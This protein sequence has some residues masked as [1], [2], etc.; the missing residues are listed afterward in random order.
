MISNVRYIVI[1]SSLFLLLTIPAYGWSLY[2]PNVPNSGYYIGINGGWG[3]FNPKDINYISEE[4]LRKSIKNGPNLSLD[5]SHFVSPRMSI[6]LGVYYVSG[7]VKDVA[8]SRILNPYDPNAYYDYTHKVDAIAPYFSVKYFFPKRHVDYFL[9]AGPMLCFGRHQEKYDATNGITLPNH[10]TF[11]YNA[12][13]VGFSTFGGLKR[14]IGKKFNINFELGYRY[15][16]TGDLHNSKGEPVTFFIQ[17]S[18]N[19]ILDLSGP[20]ATLGIAVKIF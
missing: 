16:A 10:Y 9:S 19:A 8:R 5:L 11:T 18:H 17:D 20:F 2:S 6:G 3:C 14:S 7:Q 15:L 4:I 1:I 12:T 13:G